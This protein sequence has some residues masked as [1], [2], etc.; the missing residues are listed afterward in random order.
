M[1]WHRSCKKSESKSV[2]TEVMT[3]FNRATSTFTAAESGLFFIATSNPSFDNGLASLTIQSD[4]TPIYRSDPG[5]A[6]ATCPY[7]LCELDAGDTVTYTT[8]PNYSC[9]AVYK[10]NGTIGQQIHNIKT[11]DTYNTW[12]PTET[13]K[14]LVLI[15]WNGKEENSTYV[16]DECTIRSAEECYRYY[17][18]RSNMYVLVTDNP[19]LNYFQVYGYYFGECRIAAF[20]L[21]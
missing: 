6:D 14:A 5:D 13:D 16:R 4:H 19:S 7:A 21:T 12:I 10:V 18:G 15:A 1:A 11:G 2:L 8:N 20:E 3:A 17:T 9:F